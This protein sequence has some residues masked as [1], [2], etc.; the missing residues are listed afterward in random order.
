MCSFVWGK[1]SRKQFESIIFDIFK[2][3][4]KSTGWGLEELVQPVHHLFF[5]IS[6]VK[7]LRLC[8]A[9]SCE[10]LLKVSGGG[11]QHVW[12]SQ[13]P[14]K[15]F[16][17]LHTS[18]WSPW[19]Q[20]QERSG[21]RE[22]RIDPCKGKKKT[23]IL[24]LAFHRLQSRRFHTLWSQSVVCMLQIQSRT[25]QCTPDA[26]CLSLF[27]FSNCASKTKKQAYSLIQKKK[28]SDTTVSGIFKHFVAF[29]L[30][31]L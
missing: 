19:K 13:W 10:G 4:S 25:S 7:K 28:K 18:F 29:I 14:Q 15:G 12:Q 11:W 17:I 3:M 23:C 20:G 8:K 9:S 24:L 21:T 30:I 5:L 1:H 27:V 26:S 16:T 2:N 31:H 6:N 22:P